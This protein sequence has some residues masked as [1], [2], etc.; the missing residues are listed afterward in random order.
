METVS[1][2]ERHGR[3][4][5][6]FC[7]LSGCE[8]LVHCPTH[9]AG[10]RLY[11]V[12]SDVPDIVDVY[13]GTPLGTSDHCF[14]SCALRVEQSVTEYYFS[15]TIHRTN[16]DNV[17]SADSSFTLITI[18]NSDHPLHAFNRAIVEVISRLVPTTVLFCVVDLETINGLTPAAGEL[19]ML[20]RLLIMPGVEHAVQII[21]F[22]LCLL[23]EGRKGGS[24][25][26]NAP[27]I[28]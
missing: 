6:D 18:F 7:N 13:V 11:L 28:L 2:T 27:G 4:A 16:W 25:I 26:M 5:L 21:W 14:V 22:D 1:P 23:V 10:D 15:R 17:H 19:I 12:M 3:D 9:I 20:N 8:K 24:H